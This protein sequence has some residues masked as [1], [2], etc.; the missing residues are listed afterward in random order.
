MSW[1]IISDVAGR[2]DELLLLLDKMPK[3]YNLC[4]GDMIDRGPKSREVIEFFMRASEE[5]TGNSL[6]GNHCD[7][8]V[9]HCRKTGIY[10]RGI[11]EWNGGTATLDSFNWYIPEEIVNW[12][13]NLPLYEWI[14][15]P[16]KTILVSHSFVAPHLDVKEAVAIAARPSR[17]WDEQDFEDSIIW[18]RRVPNRKEYFQIA[19]HNSNWGIRE[20]EDNQGI[21]A[22]GIDDSRNEKLTGLHLKENGEYNIYQQDYLS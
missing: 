22:I 12:V 2:Y 13:A 6:Y 4:V 5:G 7:F 3:G 10:Q 20:F 9:D 14:D 16:D 18:N 19:G 1:N 17:T 21:Y 15:L 11:W 8:L